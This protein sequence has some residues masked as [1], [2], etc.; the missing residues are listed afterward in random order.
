MTLLIIIIII[1]FNIISKKQKHI[2]KNLVV[3]VN[4]LEMERFLGCNACQ[5]SFN[6]PEEHKAYINEHKYI[7]TIL[8]SGIDII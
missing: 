7:V 8:Q 3:F 5:A 1:R 2:S 6:T 4:I